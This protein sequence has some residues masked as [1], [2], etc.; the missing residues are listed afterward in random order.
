MNTSARYIIVVVF[1]IISI[2]YIISFTHESYGRA[3]SLSNLKNK[4][5]PSSSSSSSSPASDALENFPVH[6]SPYIGAGGFNETLVTDKK[7]NATFVIL[8]R[9]SDLGNTVKSIR[10]IEDRFNRRY[11]YPY[12]LLNEEE[13]TD[14]FKQRISVLTSAKIEFGLI[15]REHWFQP[16]WIDETKAKAGRDKMVE[17]NIIYGGSFF[18]KHPLMQKYRW[19]WRIEPDVHFHCDINYDPFLFMQEKEKVYSFTITMYEYE[20]TIPTLWGHVMD[21]AKAHPEYIAKDNALGFMSTD[22]GKSYNLCH[23]WSNF[24]IADMDFWRGE[25]YQAFFDYL[26]RQGGFYYER[27]GDAPVHSIAA[28]LFAPRDKIHFFSDIGY[29]HNPYTHC[30]K[31]KGEWERGRC[32][33][34]PARSFDYDGYSCMSKW[35]KFMEK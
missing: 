32:S 17:N 24:E 33:C 7:A 30:P 26:D 34:D 20:A 18:F 31:D 28:A 22:N 14:E 35:D 19:Y 5:L 21:F 1:F 3:T 12:V 8:C 29:E 4:F 15:P 2:H 16:D 11:R 10:E 27:W 9:N 13:F 23:F 25:A 6:N